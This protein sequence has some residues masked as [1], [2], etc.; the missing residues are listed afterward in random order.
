MLSGNIYLLKFCVLHAISKELSGYVVGYFGSTSHHDIPHS[1]KKILLL[2]NLIEN[3]NIQEKCL[4][5][6]L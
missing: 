3:K 4:L 6:P 2:E 5:I 1:M